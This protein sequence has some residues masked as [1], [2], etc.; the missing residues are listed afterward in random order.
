L[1]GDSVEYIKEDCGGLRNSPEW[2]CP[3]RWQSRTFPPAMWR[4]RRWSPRPVL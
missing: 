3:S 1:A 4:S 2:N